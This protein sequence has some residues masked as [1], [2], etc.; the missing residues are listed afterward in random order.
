MLKAI[1]IISAAVVLVLFFAVFGAM[2]IY[3]F[4]DQERYEHE[5]K[6]A[7]DNPSDRKQIMQTDHK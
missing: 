4:E 1:L 2:I 7:E 6:C 5:E 3:I